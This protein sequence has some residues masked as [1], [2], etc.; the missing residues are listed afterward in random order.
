MLSKLIPNKKGQL[1]NLQSLTLGLVVNRYTEDRIDVAR[2]SSDT[3][4]ELRN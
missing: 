4:N 2:H 1:G 3:M